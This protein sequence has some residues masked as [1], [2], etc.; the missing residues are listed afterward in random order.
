[1]EFSQSEAPFRNWSFQGQNPTGE[2][3][4]ALADEFGIHSEA[5]EDCLDP[6]H[7]PKFE[8]LGPVTF[9]IA[10]AWDEAA[11]ASGDSCQALTRKVALF[12]G[13]D[14]LLTIHR[15]P[16]PYLTQLLAA[17]RG[18]PTVPVSELVFRLLD[19]VV[20]TYDVP[21]QRLDDS[22]GKWHDA[23][24]ARGPAPEL[25]ALA[26]Y[27]RQANLYKRMLWTTLQVFQ[28]FTPAGERVIPVCQSLIEDTQSLHFWS[29]ELLEEANNL[30]QLPFSLAAHRTND[31]IKVLTIFSAFFMPLT[32]LVGVYGMNF[33]YMPEI[34]WK[35]GY[36][37]SWGVMALLTLA[38]WLW[39][40]R[41]GWM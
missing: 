8:K 33:H 24:F 23:L 11:D 4:K 7:L 38:I 13:P 2:E 9:L 18:E 40:R 25:E 15:K 19:G 12:I 22:L 1:M 20:L 34:G 32:F 29:D 36:V 21:L 17:T 14:F 41:K 37:W 30:L 39:F 26:L 5:V 35:F 31:V 3:I 28:R 27:K 16:Q 10:R 6:E